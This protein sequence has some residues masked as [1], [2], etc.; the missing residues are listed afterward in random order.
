VKNKFLRLLG[1]LTFT[2]FVSSCDYTDSDSNSNPSPQDNPP[3]IVFFILDDVGIDQMEVFG[4]GGG[5]PPQLPNI[6]A[7]ANAGVSFRNMWA[8][9]ECSPSR[10]LVFEGR[11]PLRTNVLDAI[12]SVDLANSQVSPYESTTPKILREGGYSSALFV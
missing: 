10:A 7:I 2:A 8:M 6:T 9:P 11:Y 4:Y 12:L 5:S 3:N 1:L